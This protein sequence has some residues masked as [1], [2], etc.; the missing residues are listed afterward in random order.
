MASDR[1]EKR[2]DE[3]IV[4]GRVRV[5]SPFRRKTLKGKKQFEN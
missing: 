4:N 3:F 1:S 5:G 2:G